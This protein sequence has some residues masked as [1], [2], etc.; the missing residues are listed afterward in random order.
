[1]EIKGKIAIITGGASGIGA[2]GCPACST[3]ITL[4]KGS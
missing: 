1:M 4:P 3:D 2:S